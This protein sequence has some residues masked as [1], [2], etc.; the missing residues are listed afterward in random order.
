MDFPIGLRAAFMADAGRSSQKIAIVE[1]P[2]PGVGL[3]LVASMPVAPG[4]CVMAADLTVP[5]GRIVSSP[6][7]YTLQVDVDKHLDPTK[8][9]DARGGL[10][11]LL[12]HMKQPTL[13]ARFKEG[14]LEMVATRRIEVGDELGFN[15]ATTEWVMATPFQCHADQ[16]DVR[17]FLHLPKQEK[18]MLLESGLVAPHIQRLFALSSPWATPGMKGTEVE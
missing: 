9:S 6:T 14:L 15:Y 7:T 10:M 3:A 13:G 2:M 18:K 4:E 16:V 5:D 1:H 17:G 12:C 11:R 8:V